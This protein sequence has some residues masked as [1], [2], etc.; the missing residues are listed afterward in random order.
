MKQRP[1]TIVASVGARIA[2]GIEIDWSAHEAQL[3]HD[4][5]ARRILDQLKVIAMIAQIH[6]SACRAGDHD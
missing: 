5:A 4:Q 3:R 6:R 1:R 2:D